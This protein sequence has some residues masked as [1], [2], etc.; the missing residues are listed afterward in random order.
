MEVLRRLKFS[1]Y[2]K[3]ETMQIE[4]L[5]QQINEQKLGKRIKASRI[6]QA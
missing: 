6:G 2:D 1:L 5:S 4:K 3:Q